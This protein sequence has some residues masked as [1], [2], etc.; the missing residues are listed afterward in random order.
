M[1]LSKGACLETAGLDFSG[2]LPYP[3]MH[4]PITIEDGVWIGVHAIILGGVTVG[5]GSVIGAG[6]VVSKDVPPNSIVT[7]QPGRIRSRTGDDPHIR[8]AQ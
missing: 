6:A 8:I 7:G 4:R 1:R 3:H 5:A 2:P